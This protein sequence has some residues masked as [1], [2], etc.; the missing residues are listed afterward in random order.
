MPTSQTIMFT[1]PFCR[2]RGM[3]RPYRVANFSRLVLFYG[4]FVGNGLDRSGRFTV[5]AII[6]KYHPV[7]AGHAP[8]ATVC[9]N[10]YNGL[11]CRGGIYAARA[12]IPLL[13][14][15]RANRTGRIYASPTNLP[16]MGALPITTCRP[17]SHYIKTCPRGGHTRIIIFYLLS[18]I[19]KNPSIT[20]GNTVCH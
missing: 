16:K 11:A 10:E 18:I 5:I 6:K 7:G 20:R 19:Y 12:A 3:P 13:P 8:P 2:G 9:Y 14:T 4:W 15:Y 17:T 1:L